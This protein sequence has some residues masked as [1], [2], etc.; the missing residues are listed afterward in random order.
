MIIMNMAR[1]TRTAERI[2]SSRSRMYLFRTAH[3]ASLMKMD[4]L[5]ITILMNLKKDI[6]AQT[7]NASKSH[8]QRRV[9]QTRQGIMTGQEKR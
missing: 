8:G 4:I 7:E 3:S 6:T 5:Y 1:H 2:S 9:I